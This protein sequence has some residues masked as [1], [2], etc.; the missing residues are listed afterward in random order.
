MNGIRAEPRTAGLNSIKPD[1]ITE[2]TRNAGAADRFARDSGSQI[3]AIRK[4]NQGIFSIL[5]AHQGSVASDS[6]EVGAGLQFR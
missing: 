2:A 5:P 6:G 4:A 1:M 3:S